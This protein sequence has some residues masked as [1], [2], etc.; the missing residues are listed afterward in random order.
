MHVFEDTIDMCKIM[1]DTLS[2]IIDMCKIMLDTSQLSM[3]LRT[4]DRLGIADEKQYRCMIVHGTPT[5][6]G[7]LL[8]AHW[9][10]RY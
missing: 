7:L 3:D 10:F 5:F 2:I 6:G 1:L 9:R 8:A 4:T